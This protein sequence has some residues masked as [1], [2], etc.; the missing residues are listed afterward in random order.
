M[1]RCLHPTACTAAR[2]HLLQRKREPGM[3]NT[4]M[5]QPGG[6]WPGAPRCILSAKLPFPSS[7][8]LRLAEAGR[9]V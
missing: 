7:H 4:G 1:L 9:L 6:S 5:S 2:L 8:C 3:T